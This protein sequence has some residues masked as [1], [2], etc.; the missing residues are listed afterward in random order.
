MSQRSLLQDAYEGNTPSILAPFT[1]A[2]QLSR[3]VTDRAY[4][5]DSDSA[6]SQREANSD[7]GSVSYKPDIT[8]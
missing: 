5:R 3:V 6:S 7:E 1:T 4:C 2:L 8:A